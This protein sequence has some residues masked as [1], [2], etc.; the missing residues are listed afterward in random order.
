MENV[1]KGWEEGGLLLGEWSERQKSLEEECPPACHSEG[2]GRLPLTGDRE[3]SPPD[4]LRLWPAHPQDATPV[5]IQAVP[6]PTV[7]TREV[8]S[9][10]EGTSISGK[11]PRKGR[12]E[13]QEGWGKERVRAQQKGVLSGPACRDGQRAGNPK[14]GP[15]PG[16]GTRAGD[17]R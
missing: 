15:K 10:E 9:K 17:F 11:P 2:L 4:A 13:E 6:L 3:D 7:G 16:C 14:N 8:R 5:G 12:G 1:C